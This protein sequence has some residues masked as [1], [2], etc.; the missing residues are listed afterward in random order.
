VG[1]T[2]AAGSRIASTPASSSSGTTACAALA[3]LWLPQAFD[4]QV[5]GLPVFAVFYGL[6]WIATVPPTSG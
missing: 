4:A 3:L 1:T 2:A 5:L 6:D